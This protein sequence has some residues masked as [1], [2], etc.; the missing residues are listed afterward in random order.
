MYDLIGTAGNSTTLLDS[1]RAIAFDSNP[2]IYYISDSNNNRIMRYTLSSTVGTVVAG[3]NG[4]GTSNTQLSNPRGL[5]YDS[6]T[7]SLLIANAGANNVVRWVIGA[8]SWTLDAGS[9]NG[10]SGSGSTTFYNPWD[11]TLDS[12]GNMY[13]ADR[14]NQRIQLFLAGQSNGTTIAGATGSY[15][16]SST[17][18]DEPLSVAL[19]SYFNVYA[20]DSQNS[21]VQKFSYY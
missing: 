2:N 21:R 19:D 10:S 12:V 4:A 9:I 16:T 14:Y 5:Y 6:T 17:L 11:V 3:G 13:V 20:A 15:G 8:S 1:P 18:L 7:S